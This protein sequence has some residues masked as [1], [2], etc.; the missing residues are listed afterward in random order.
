MCSESPGAGSAGAG[1][2]QTRPGDGLQGRGADIS[3][4]PGTK[5]RWPCGSLGDERDCGAMSQ[6]REAVGGTRAASSGH[7]GPEPGRC[8]CS[9]IP[10]L[11]KKKK[12]SSYEKRK[13]SDVVL[14]ELR[15]GSR[16]RRAWLE[17]SSALDRHH[18]LG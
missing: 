12:R 5:R 7:P 13:V 14:V 8:T 16:I 11:R 4:E 10:F 15:T 17:S 18:D 9:P 6:E 1:L 2:G 3:A